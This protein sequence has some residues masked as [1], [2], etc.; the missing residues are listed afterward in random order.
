MFIRRHIDIPTESRCC[1]GHTLDDHLMREAF[2]SLTS[3]KVENRPI[4]R[5]NLMNMLQTYRAR[6]NS[7]KHLDFNDYLYM[8][9]ADYTKLTGFTRAQHTQI[10]S[11]IPST[12]L[13]NSVARSALSMLKKSRWLY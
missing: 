8:T 7:K 6:V 10:L 5:Q 3:Y 12:A 4:S 13:K 9:D 1:K 11:C 2:L